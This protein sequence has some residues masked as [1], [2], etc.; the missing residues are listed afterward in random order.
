MGRHALGARIVQIQGIIFS[1]RPEEAIAAARAAI[2][3]SADKISVK[4]IWRLGAMSS[5]T[6]LTGS[7]L[8]AL[9]IVH[10]GIEADAAWAVAHVDED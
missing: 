7:A 10:G 8:L 2:P 3:S 6:T 1:A 9:A 4:D 5:I